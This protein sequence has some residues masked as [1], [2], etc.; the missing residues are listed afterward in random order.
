MTNKNDIFFLIFVSFLLYLPKWLI[1][2]F[3]FEETSSIK[4]IFESVTDGYHYFPLVKYLAIFEFNNSFSPFIE[5]LENVMLPFYSVAIPS[6]F[7]KFVGSFSFIIIEYIFIFLFILTLYKIF[8]LYY[9]RELSIFYAL[10][11]FVTP[12]VFSLFPVSDLTYLKIIKDDIFTLRFPRPL[13]TSWFLFI[14]LYIILSLEKKEFFTKKNFFILGIILGVTL[15]SFYY[16]FFLQVSILIIYLFYRYKLSIF[17]KL[18]Q[19]W[20]STIILILTLIII[21]SPMIIN[22]NAHEEDYTRRLGI[23]SLNIEQKIILIKYYLSAY[24]KIEL[25][26]SL[27]LST[28]LVL[29]LNFKKFYNYKLTNIFYIFFVSSLTA[30][31]LFILLT[32]KSGILYHFNNT[33]IIFL[34]LLILIII[35]NFISRLPLKYLQTKIINLASIFLIIC[36]ILTNIFKAVPLNQNEIVKERNE[37]N[38]LSKIIL[39]K[40]NLKESTLLTFDDRF[41]VWAVLNDIKYL[42]LT[43]FILSPK[44]DEMIEDDLIKS[45]KLLNLD[46]KEFSSFISNKKSSWRYINYNLSNFFFYKYMANPI[47]T[48]NDSKNFSDEINEYIMKSSPINFQQTIIPNDELVRLENKFAKTTLNKFNYPDIIILNKKNKFLQNVN[49]IDNYCKIYKKEFFVMFIKKEA[50]DNCQ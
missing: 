21:I 14:F 42:N 38:D 29:T 18:L 9:S 13:I 2:Y 3:Y 10:V 40:Y 8:N 50:S 24:L 5:D 23:I 11:I 16:F 6:I 30:P 44:K 31:L 17:S 45:F 41:M 32:N 28:L 33:V 20:K 49:S 4:V 19:N 26:I 39:K 22:M 48:F 27:I 46:K 35:F 12:I 47:K 36:C 37:F 34:F 25:I 7:Y 43:Y 15:S 1:S